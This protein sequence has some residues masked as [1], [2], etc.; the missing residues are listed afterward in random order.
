MSSVDD[1]LTR[2]S[3]VDAMLDY[4]AASPAGTPAEVADGLVRAACVQGMNVFE[5]FLRDRSSEWTAQLTN[6]RISPSQLPAGIDRY[7]SRIVETLPRKFAT[8]A[9]TD[10][11]AL[12]EDV[13]KCLRS[14]SDTSFVAHDLFFAWTGSNVQVT[15]IETM[16]Q[17]AGIKD[18]W[19]DL[20]TLWSRVDSRY[21]GVGARSLMTDFASWRHEA[22]HVASRVPPL[23]N[24]QAI[25][26]NIRW[27]ALLVDGL[28]S[29]SLW[30]VSTHQPLETHLAPKIPIRRLIKDGRYWKE[31]GPKNH[32]RAVRR[33]ESLQEA[34]AE[35]R[36]RAMMTGDFTVA[37]EGYDVA[38]WRAII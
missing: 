36:T 23:I 37:F 21:P 3:A 20:S 12:M 32:K 2:L 33:H 24:A 27:T 29:T 7:R 9:E 8:T 6:A 30:R 35:S 4:A 22:A 5:Q 10:R 31:F 15:D 34:L 16:V 26:R 11:A 17:L 25:T 38:D 14:F 28:I 1:L 18:P 19:K 13:A